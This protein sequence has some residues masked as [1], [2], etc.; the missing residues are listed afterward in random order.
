MGNSQHSLGSSRSLPPCRKKRRRELDAHARRSLG[1]WALTIR[2]DVARLGVDVFDLLTSLDG[3]IK[4]FRDEDV[5]RKLRD[6][7]GHLWG[8]YSRS[9]EE[10]K[11][12]EVEPAAR[13]ALIQETLPA[14]RNLLAE[15]SQ[16]LQCCEPPSKECLR[17]MQAF[18]TEGKKLIE[19]YDTIVYNAQDV[20]DF[21]TGRLPSEKAPEG[22]EDVRYGSVAPFT[23]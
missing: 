18:L 22:F 16:R 10:E 11:R 3:I 2:R 9:L 21:Y 23:G 8:V 17:D 1:R 13:L 19:K 4:S 15:T 12:G 5:C 20:F 7:A 14:L 6:S